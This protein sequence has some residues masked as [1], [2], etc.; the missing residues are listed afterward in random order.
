MLEDELRG[1]VGGRGATNK[2]HLRWPR[3]TCARRKQAEA[4][5]EAQA[6]EAMGNNNLIITIIIVII[7]VVVIMVV[8]I[9]VIIIVVII[10]AWV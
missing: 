6:V 5:A 7:I 1:I 9:I 3:E 4:L 8:I 10:S 2:M